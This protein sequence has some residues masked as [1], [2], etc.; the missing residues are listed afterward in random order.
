MTW[1]EKNAAGLLASSSLLLLVA[2]ALLLIV[3]RS[4]SERHA[5]LPAVLQTGPRHRRASS[6]A[7]PPASTSPRP[8]WVYWEGAASASVRACVACIRG[9]CEASRGLFRLRVVEPSQLEA[10][11]LPRHACLRLGPPALRS[12]FIRLH[13]LHEF[14]GLWLDA[15]CAPVEALEAWALPSP[16]TAAE[17]GEAY[18]RAFVNPRN[19]HRAEA[20]CVET[21]VMSCSPRH[22]LVADWLDECMRSSALCSGAE[23]RGVAESVQREDP[24]FGLDLDAE[25]HYVY[26][27]L[28]R[29]LARAPRGIFSY[30]NCTLYNTEHH[31]FFLLWNPRISAQDVLQWPLPRLLEALE[32]HGGS[33]CRR[34]PVFKF[35]RHDRQRL[36]A[37]IEDSRRAGGAQA[38]FGPG[39]L[40]SC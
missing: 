24:E 20:P 34:P 10:Y 28:Q 36:D 38:V 3:W 33:A 1:R 21:S 11:G 2:A 26:W 17:S 40:L 27:C 35:I 15:S 6:A 37:A 16:A 22:P 9:A 39:S 13:L 14:G 19:T 12:D 8:V 30:P 7:P 5:A 31:H 32:A 23:L 25:Y 29:V 18:F 4:G